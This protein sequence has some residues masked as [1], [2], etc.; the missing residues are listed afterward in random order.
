MLTGRVITCTKCTVE[1]LLSTGKK[2][3]C[4]IVLIMYF[5]VDR[6]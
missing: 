6:Y 3:T 2:C 4:I 1:V 5:V